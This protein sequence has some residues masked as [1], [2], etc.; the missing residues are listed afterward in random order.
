MSKGAFWTVVVGITG[1]V[2]FGASERGLAPPVVEPPASVDRSGSSGSIPRHGRATTVMPVTRQQEEELLAALKDRAPSQ[3][4]RL[5]R[6]RKERPGVYRW[7][8][9]K[10]WAWYQRWK[11]L[12]EEIQ[13]A[14]V[15][16]HLERMKIFRLVLAYRA[17]TSEARRAKL[18]SELVES[19]KRQFDAEQ[20]RQEYRIEQLKAQI[21]QLE[22]ELARRAARR[23]EIVRQRV[24]AVLKGGALRPFGPRPRTRPAGRGE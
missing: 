6:L 11:D 10:T 16:E 20:K 5:I 12:P 24:E 1:L 23:D 7:A 19:I 8:L 3:Y 4:E 21:R 9:R 18:K 13:A 15:T 2:I 17:A 14:A 22:Q